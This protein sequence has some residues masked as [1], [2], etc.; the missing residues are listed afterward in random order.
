MNEWSLA[1]AVVGVLLSLS[2]AAVSA[3]YFVGRLDE[4]VGKLERQGT[5]H[6]VKSALDEIANKR[7]EAI[8]KLAGSL[9]GNA[10]MAVYATSGNLPQG[11][12]YCGDEGTPT[13]HDR[14]LLGTTTISDIGKAAGSED[15]S[16][17]LSATI[18]GESSGEHRPGKPGSPEDFA[19]NIHEGVED[20]GPRNWYHEHEVRTETDPASSLPP[21]VKVLFLCRVPAS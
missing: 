10:M 16:H 19:D 17:H 14:F 15:H 3:A 9:P 11:W 21:S 2:L 13:I 12:V 20:T 4:R 18:K 5:P 8:A 6:S 7:D 1:I